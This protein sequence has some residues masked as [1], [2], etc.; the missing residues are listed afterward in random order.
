MM[1]AH[2]EAEVVRKLRIAFDAAGIVVSRATMSGGNL[3]AWEQVSPE[4]IVGRW[5]QNGWR[6]DL[7]RDRQPT[8]LALVTDDEGM[9]LAEQA[10]AGAHMTE[11]PATTRR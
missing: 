8:R 5:L 4:G 1:D 7:V 2:T 11:D 3:R 9:E 10:E 6:V